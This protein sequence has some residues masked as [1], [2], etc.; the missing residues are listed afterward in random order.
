MV[1]EMLGDV[2]V[3]AARQFVSFWHARSLLALAK[4]G[5]RFALARLAT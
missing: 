4:G 2:I 1:I 5:Y 3:M